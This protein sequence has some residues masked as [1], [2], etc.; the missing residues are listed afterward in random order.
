MEKSNVPTYFTGQ[1]ITVTLADGRR[2]VIQERKTN[3]VLAMVIS[4]GRSH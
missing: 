4:V 2:Q 3:G 1:M